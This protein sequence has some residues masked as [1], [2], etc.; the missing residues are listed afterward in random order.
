MFKFPCQEMQDNVYMYLLQCLLSAKIHL[1]RYSHR[2]KI[3]ETRSPYIYKPYFLT[4]KGQANDRKVHGI[5]LV[6]HFV[7]PYDIW[8][9]RTTQKCCFRLK[10]HSEVQARFNDYIFVHDTTKRKKLYQILWNEILFL[11]PQSCSLWTEFFCSSS[12]SYHLLL[13]WYHT[14]KLNIISS[15]FKW[16]QTSFVQLPFQ[17][18][19]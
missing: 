8:N 13:Q 1:S 4:T 2:H 6:W 14:A 17:M 11:G 15:T 9:A 18:L 19:Q 3:E 10:I 5:L 16:Q 7:F 12:L